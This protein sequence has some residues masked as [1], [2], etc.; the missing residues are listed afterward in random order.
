M[1][2]DDVDIDALIMGFKNNDYNIRTI[3]QKLLSIIHK[4][5]GEKEVKLTKFLQELIQSL[6]NP[7]PSGAPVGMVKSEDAHPP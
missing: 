2:G 3:Q 4:V 7:K 6:N 5:K 1:D